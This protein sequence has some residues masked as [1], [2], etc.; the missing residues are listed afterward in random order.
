MKYRS[1]PELNHM[2]DVFLSNIKIR[3]DIGTI[4]EFFYA[5]PS[6]IKNRTATK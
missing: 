6:K 5:V 3:N 2:V 4:M 1:T